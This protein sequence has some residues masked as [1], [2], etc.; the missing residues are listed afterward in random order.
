MAKM[1][2][3]LKPVCYLVFMFALFANLAKAAYTVEEITGTPFDAT[4][5]AV[6]WT[7]DSSLTAYPQD[8]DFELV[9]IG[10]TF[11][12]GEIAYT[13]VRILSNGAL[14]FGDDQGFYKDYTNESLPI[15]SACSGGNCPGYEEP[16]DRVILGYWDDLEPSLGGSVTYDTLGSG[17]DRRFVA[18]WDSV[19]RYN[20]ASTAYSVQIVLYETGEV[21]FRYGDDDATGTSATIG[22]E[23][24]D[25]D[26]TEFSHSSDRVSD[27]KDLF[28]VREFPAI[29]SVSA[30]CTDFNTVTVQFD[31]AVQ[32]SRATNTANY[33]IDN[34]VTI[35]AATLVDS[36]TVELTT[37][38]LSAGTT[39]TL[40]TT[41]PDQSQSFS[42]TTGAV[43]GTFADNFNSSSYSNNT[44]DLSWAGSWQEENDYGGYSSGDIL[45]SGNRLVFDDDQGDG[46]AI[47]RALDL[48]PY[49]NVTLTFDYYTQG[50][51]ESNDRFA[52][53][54][55]TNG[56]VSYTTLAS[57]SD[58]TSGS[59]SINLTP[60]ISSSTRIRFAVTQG[61]GG[62]GEFMNI[63]NVAVDVSGSGTAC[64]NPL[65][66]LWR[67][68]S[69]P[70]DGTSGEVLDSSGNDLNG[71]TVGGASSVNTNPA[72]AG[73]PGTCSYAD[74]NGS[75]Q[76]IEVADN[77]LLDLSDEL[78]ITAWVYPNA[79]PGSGLMSILSK[80]ENYE[81]HITP[82]GEINWWWNDD[83]GTTREFDSVGAN[84][85]PGNWYHIA[86]S[87]TSGA[88]AIYVNGVQRATRTYTGGLRTNS[89]PLQIGQD[90]V[91]AGR[92][93]NG[94]IDEVRIYS[95]AL[96]SS[97][98]NDIYADTHDCPSCTLGGFAITQPSYGL[99]CPT[100]RAEIEIRAMCDDGVTTHDAYAGIVDLSS[101][102]NSLS[103]FYSVSSGGTEIS[104]IT[105][106]GT[107]NGRQSVYLYHK[108]ENADVE[109]TATD[110]V[111]GLDGTA[112]SGTDFRS[113]GLQVSLPNA[114][115]CANSVTLTLTAIGQDSGG[116]ASCTTLTGFDGS[117][118]LKAWYSVNIH[119][120]GQPDADTVSTP[121]VIGGT[122]FN[123]QNKP[124]TD[125][126][127]LTFNNGVATTSLTYGDSG[128]I[129]KLD[130]EHDV[131]PYGDSDS[132]LP[133][134]D[135]SAAGIIVTP[136][137]LK[138]TI[139]TS[140]SDCASEDETCSKFVK[141]GDPFSM[142]VSGVCSDESVAQSYQ[143][144][145]NLSHGL[146]APSGGWDGNI[147]MSQ[148]TISLSDNGSKTITDQ[149]F[150]EVGVISLT[151]S[152]VDN[153]FGQ[154]VTESPTIT[155]GR[156]Y[157]AYLDVTANDPTFK[158]DSMCDFIYQDQ[159][160]GYDTGAEPELTITA[161]N[162][163]GSV[164]LNYDSSFYKLGDPDMRYENKL[165]DTHPS[166]F[167]D[168]RVG[169]SYIYPAGATLD[170]KRAVQIWDDILTFQKS[171]YSTPDAMDKPFAADIDLI[172]DSNT[173]TDDD[174]ACYQSNPP[175]GTCLPYTISKVDGT[176]IRYGRLHMENAFGPETDPLT[177]PI[178]VEYWDGSNFVVNDADGCTSYSTENSWITMQDY[179]DNL[180]DGETKLEIDGSSG[181]SEA[182]VGGKFNY[183]SRKQMYLT[184]PGLG[185]D[186]SVELAPSVDVW[187]QHDWDADG[188]LDNPTS[189]ATFGQYRGHDRIIYWREVVN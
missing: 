46:P 58:D 184:A 43:S 1:K 88:Q 155:V 174:G 142:T 37:S 151:A 20:G 172:F 2:L 170:G 104:S 124:L 117:K 135:G 61:Y 107:E 149:S 159:E 162:R 109:V 140:N 34:G 73:D 51:L 35:T 17:S 5:T 9:N 144:A 187:L 23:V 19:P 6:A 98:I 173:L 131:S 40:S 128:E 76:Y 27:A 101:N 177:V 54:V 52:V 176:Q 21:L 119:T 3:L 47:Y 108:N 181:A 130:F 158:H 84:I 97:E 85:T 31:S 93:F 83:T 86:I 163:N 99:A 118:S 94:R 105:F 183:G 134:L 96:D 65:V 50:F 70:W 59:A 14:H 92:Y 57:Y 160:F 87:Y 7:N 110:R 36:T 136:E 185:N 171:S 145:V 72:I 169:R 157:P 146:L 13:Q 129:L 178:Q 161:Y 100:T 4:S 114:F 132:G 66:G 112:S 32:P 30:S 45:I 56:G 120:S 53:Q 78:T 77:D 60:Y 166:V 10:F 152:A 16:A 62:S 18:T 49:D 137:H 26:Y 74:F 67:M 33:S 164:T 24:D 102:E 91:F 69:G 41:Y 8:D 139:D 106:D 22:I 180:D 115:N 126:L 125:N 121:M 165:M 150:D 175:A 71:R 138:I 12:L 116:G 29:A 113:A 111:T 44:G 79:L 64:I 38:T 122:S 154:N 156:F 63:D 143:G 179:T 103:E 68:E 82:A 89:D 167:N 15:T 127:S 81:F 188:D 153:Y 39:Y 182:F 11:Y 95:S 25:S 48:S 147:S 42:L 141:A 186:G 80:D 189:R 75:T 148:A 168:N 123:D 28:W 90:Q 133:V 55:S